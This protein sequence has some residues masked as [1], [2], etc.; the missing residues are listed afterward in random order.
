MKVIYGISQWRY[1]FATAVCLGVF[2]G[3]HV[4][5][6]SVLKK[7]HQV[8]KSANLASVVFTFWPPPFK[9]I[10][11]DST[12]PHILTSLP[13]KLKLIE[14]FGIDYCLIGE[15][16]KEFMQLKAEKFLKEN[17][18][19]KLNMQELII[20]KDFRFG[21]KTESGIEELERWSGE[22]GYK[23][24]P[25]DTEKIKGRR[26][27]SSW[28]RQLITEGNLTEAEQLLGRKVSLFGE[29]VRGEGEG[30]KLGYPT[31]NINPHQEVLPPEGVYLA[32]V[33]VGS[34]VFDAVLSIGR[35][36]TISPKKKPVVEAYLLD[37]SGQ[38]LYGKQIQIH[39]LKH[40]RE[41]E[42]FSSP[43]VLSEAIAHD[44]KDAKIKLKS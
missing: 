44:V 8:A 29:V 7:A 31:A 36:V 32:R 24:F 16:S 22:Y 33:D 26:I 13:H 42:K 2:D 20:G 18:I 37:Y 6:A 3:V 41:Q 11:R 17:L 27:S 1:D 43:K 28:I 14:E 23:V 15:F 30:K 39:I 35:Q 5:H 10:F 34:K 4:G 40:M 21:A 19:D 9:L 38:D 12:D 25:V